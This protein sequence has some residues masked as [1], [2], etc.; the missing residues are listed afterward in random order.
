MGK[1]QI[2][3]PNDVKVAAVAF[4]SRALVL[5]WMFL[6]AGLYR[7]LD[8]STSLQ[9]FACIIGEKDVSAQPQPSSSSEW[10][11]NALAPWDSVFFVRI[12]KCGYEVDMFNAFFPLY[13]FLM[14]LI[15]TA[16]SYLRLDFFFQRFAIEILYLVVGL[17]IN[18]LAFCFAAVALHHL[19]VQITKSY[20]LSNIA[21]IFFC[22]NPSSV[23]Y[24][25]AYTE[26]LFAAFTWS[27]LVL[28]HR[29]R[30]WHGTFL[31]MAATG[32]RSNGILSCFFIAYKLIV[33]D[34]RIRHG[35]RI[36]LSLM[37]M[38]FPLIVSCTLI[39]FP[40]LAMQGKLKLLYQL[41]SLVVYFCSK[42]K[43]HVM[44]FFSVRIL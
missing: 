29:N 35:S 44:D 15:V 40:N 42:T 13:P 14:R 32:V 18:L 2:S 20:R 41:P 12:A 10:T 5:G 19:S 31:L 8:T 27:G 11:L 25:A 33:S 36:P 22:F 4:A 43:N 1:V 9:N 16:L 34:G 37:K 6:S 26:A 38:M 17:V 30:L 39:T 7:K 21:V 28:L 3:I 24:S 23:F